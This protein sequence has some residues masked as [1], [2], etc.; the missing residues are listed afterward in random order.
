MRASSAGMLEMYRGSRLL[1]WLIDDRGQLLFSYYT[2]YLHFTPDD[3]GL[4]P[5]RL[6]TICK[7][8]DICSAGRAAAMLHLMRR[9]RY[10]ESDTNVADR[11]RRQLLATPAF[12]EMFRQ[13]WRLHFAAMAPLFSDGEDL[14]YALEDPAFF[15][16]FVMTMESVFRGGFRFTTD[17]QLRRVVD[18][19]A[20]IM[21]MASLIAGGAADDTVPPSR[22]VP[23]SVSALAKRFSVSRAH[24]VG[25]LD[26]AASAELLT[27]SQAEQTYVT[28][29]PR[30]AHELQNFFAQLFLCF[31]ACARVALKV[32]A[33]E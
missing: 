9:A 27:R 30:L 22:P 15:R 19:N 16:T 2:L 13:R 32:T 1:N 20:G 6:K 29:L 5:T 25:L 8:L 33:A 10:I 17:P 14:R 26:D 21:I 24:V 3:G 11:R 4:S 7:D 12:I 18:R 31:S 28:V 23:L